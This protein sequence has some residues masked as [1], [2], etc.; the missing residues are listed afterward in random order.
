MVGVLGIGYLRNGEGGDKCG[1]DFIIASRGV[2]AGQAREKAGTLLRHA[3]VVP[4]LDAAASACQCPA[5]G[6][7]DRCTVRRC[8]A[9]DWARQHQRLRGL[10]ARDRRP[11]WLALAS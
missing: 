11:G 6:P 10:D 1:D 5:A 9:L 8:N 3:R 4:L 7:V 2:V